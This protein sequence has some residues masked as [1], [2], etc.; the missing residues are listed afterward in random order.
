MEAEAA[1]DKPVVESLMLRYGSARHGTVPRIHPS[2]TSLPHTP[3]PLSLIL[4]DRSPSPGTPACPGTV[5][6][7]V[8]TRMHACTVHACAVYAYEQRPERG[9]DVGGYST[10][11]PRSYLLRSVAPAPTISY[12][13]Q[14]PLTPSPCPPPHTLA[15]TPRRARGFG[16]SLGGESL[17]RNGSRNSLTAAALQQ[18]PLSRL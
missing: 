2:P 3:R 13:N 7:D 8:G 17:S 9:C 1:L 15:L 12:C 6:H 4:P 18:V 11:P 16:F 5:R 14:P 10:Y